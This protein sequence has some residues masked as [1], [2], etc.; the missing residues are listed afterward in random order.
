[1]PGMHAATCDR[2]V[3][4]STVLKCM[5]Q[6]FMFSHLAYILGNSK[7]FKTATFVIPATAAI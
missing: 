5:T 4:F 2:V 6:T 1:M 7:Y 3:H